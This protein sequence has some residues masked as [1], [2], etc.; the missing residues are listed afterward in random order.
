LLNGQILVH[1]VDIEPFVDR[2]VHVTLK[3]RNIE[4]APH[5]RE[6]LIVYCVEELW[7]ASRKY[8]AR[9]YRS[10]QQFADGV[11]RRKVIDWLRLD[12]GRSRWAFGDHIYERPKVELLSLDAGAG[13][14]QL[15]SSLERG[16][17][18]REDCSLDLR[19]V[20]GG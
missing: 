1:G 18:D 5:R 7:I 4:L 15:G 8:D 17:F 20:L 13:G 3:R 14:D 12:V 9:R 19:R 6:D 2:V 10:F 11:T 16:A